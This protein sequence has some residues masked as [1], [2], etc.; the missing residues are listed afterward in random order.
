[1]KII[2]IY[3]EKGCVHDFT[4][5]KKSKLAIH[6][7]ILILADLGYLGIAKLHKNSWIPHKKSKHV[8]LTKEQKRDNRILASLRIQV[9]IANRRCKIFKAAKDRYRGKHKNCGKVWNV[10]ASLVNLRYQV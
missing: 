9:E 2:C 8:P 4:V 5:L 3:L 10:I 7:K 6:S 1:M